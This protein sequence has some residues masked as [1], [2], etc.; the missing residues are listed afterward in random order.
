MKKQSVFLMLLAIPLFLFANGQIEETA[1]DGGPVQIEFSYWANNVQNED[2]KALAASFEDAFPQYR[3]KLN[4]YASTE[5]FWNAL[6]IAISS[7]TAPDII[8]YTDEGASEYI[9]NGVVAP[10]DDL[11]ETVGFNRDEIIDSLWKGWS[12]E[13]ETFGIPRDAATSMLFINKS[14]FEAAGLTKYPETMEELSRTAKILTT[15]EV[16]GLCLNLHEFH[17]T[18]YA[19]AFGGNWDYGKS[20]DSSENKRALEFIVDL[21]KS[22]TAVT[23]SALGA[24]WDGEVFG[25]GKAAMS[26]GGAW[27]VG[28]LKEAAPDM[29]YAIIPIPVGKVPSQSAFSGGYSILSQSDTKEGAMLFIKHALTDENQRD[30]MGRMGSA[31]SKKA[32]LPEFLAENEKI[33]PFFETLGDYGMP[34]SYPVETR[35]FVTMMIDGLETIIYTND[36]GLTVESLTTDLQ[37]QFGM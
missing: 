2:Y 14:L 8:A 25:Q 11:M 17:I 3:M 19:H 4:Q 9:A 6:P 34:F 33:Q 21:F 20:I 35:N 29:D 12:Y 18:Q 5:E 26:T 7:Q 28:Y 32:L 15:D 37:D 22:G 30:S 23:P 27:Y 36:S 1:Q 31:S 13:G 10:L 16:Y 24:S